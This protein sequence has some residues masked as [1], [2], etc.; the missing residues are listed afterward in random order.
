M[1]SLYSGSDALFRKGSSISTL[2]L[3]WIQKE[4]YLGANHNQEHYFWAKQM[5]VM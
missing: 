1:S 5:F 2:P 3:L 4:N